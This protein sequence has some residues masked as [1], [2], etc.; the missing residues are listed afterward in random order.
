MSIKLYTGI[1]FR[2]TTFEALHARMLEIRP[3]LVEEM[4]R[5]CRTAILHMA[6]TRFD[7]E[8]LCGE[9]PQ[10]VMSRA[11]DQF[12]ER[13]VKANQGIYNDPFDFKFG[14]T[15]MPY[16]GRLYGIH[17]GHRGLT[18]RFLSWMEPEDYHYQDQSD[19]PEDVSAKD[20]QERRKTWTAIFGSSSGWVPS[21]VG[22]TFE[23]VPETPTVYYGQREDFRPAMPVI[24]RSR[25]ERIARENLMEEVLAGRVPESGVT[26]LG[27]H[28]EP[29][30]TVRA[31]RE[32][33][34]SP[35][36]VA[37]LEAELSTVAQWLKP[38]ITFEDLWPLG[39]SLTLEALE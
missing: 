33:I 7:H 38:T 13:A 29:S 27:S 4:L 24:D 30:S 32:W 23:L 9:I 22:S 34:K 11:I 14:V 12:R 16:A 5:Q 3:L 19:E 21:E 15:V 28:K 20:W 31:A 35:A 17:L 25:F 10:K 26:V 1:R 18:E 39:R 36:G 2:Q 37:R 8:R 6:A